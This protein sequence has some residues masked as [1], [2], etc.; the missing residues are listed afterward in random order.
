MI[1]IEFKPFLW[2]Y[3]F[4]KLDKNDLKYIWKCRNH[5]QIRK[6]MINHQEISW[7]DHCNFISNLH[8]S[9][10]KT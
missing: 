8:K 6:W 10:N 3:D 1:P 7:A 4:N 9:K 2:S 5:S